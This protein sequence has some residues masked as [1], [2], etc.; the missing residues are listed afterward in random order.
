LEGTT[1]TNFANTAHF[2]ADGLTAG[3]IVLGETSHDNRSLAAVP[4]SGTTFL[5]GG[6]LLI[7][8]LIGRACRP[9]TE[10]N[11]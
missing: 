1:V 9:S 3:V 5:L 8:A 6:G 11:H 2:N 10:V 4:E 7:L